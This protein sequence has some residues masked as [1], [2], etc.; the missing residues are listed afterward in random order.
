MLQPSGPK[1]RFKTPAV[2]GVEQ[3][4]FDRVDIVTETS[5]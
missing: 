4:A 3:E 2:I 5:Y 1:R